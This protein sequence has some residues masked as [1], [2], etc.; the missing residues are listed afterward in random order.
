MDVPTI[1][2]AGILVCYLSMVATAA[3][4][5]KSKARAAVEEARYRHETINY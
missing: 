4:V 2:A 1:V 5:E 3:S